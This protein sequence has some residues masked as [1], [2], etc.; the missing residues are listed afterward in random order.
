MA[1]SLKE[2]EKL[3]GKGVKL[4]P[5]PRKT[6][7]APQPQ[8]PKQSFFERFNLLPAG[9]GTLGAV[10]GAVAGPPGIIAGGAAG[11]GLGE[12]IEQLITGKTNIKGIAAETAFG[13]AGGVLGRVLGVGARAA[14]A[15]APEPVKKG[16]Q[17]AARVFTKA[18]TIPTKLA[19]RLKPIDTS[20]ELLKHGLGGKDLGFMKRFAEQ[21]TGREGILPR[22]V[23]DIVAKVGKDIPLPA[24]ITPAK[25]VLGRSAL[26]TP[27]QQKT[28]FQA[29]A[30]T[31]TPGKAPN[32]LNPMDALDSI[33]E[34]EKV[35]FQYINSST[36]LSPN[37]IN[38][39]IGKAYLASSDAIKEVLERS[40]QGADLV[41]LSKTPQLLAQLKQISP[42]LAD[43]FNK[44]KTLADVRAV[45]APFVRLSQMVDITEEAAQSVG[46]GL[47][48]GFGARTLGGVGGFAV[49]GPVGAAAGIASAPF[50]E[51]VEG[52]IRAPLTTGA[53]RLF[54]ILGRARGGIGGL[55][56]GAGA[57]PVSQGVRA[58]LGQVI[59]RAAAL[60]ISPEGVPQRPEEAPTTIEELLS[61]QGVADGGLQG[62]EGVLGEQQP[63]QQ[64]T[65]D[66]VVRAH[67]ELDPEFAD[68]IQAAFEAQSLGEA[69]GKLTAAQEQN[70]SKLDRAD[71]LLSTYESKLDEI[72]T[73]EGFPARLRG[74]FNKLLG[75]IGQA[76]KVQTFTDLRNGTVA[77]LAKALGEVGN[78]SK[79]DIEVAK[80][81]IPRLTDTTEEVR[82]KLETIRS[83]ISKSRQNLL[84][85]TGKVLPQTGGIN[86]QLL[87]Q[88][89]QGGG[90][91]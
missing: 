2:L 57:G 52:A 69:G 12:F 3:L 63:T 78:L 90:F 75:S 82:L 80:A 40:I 5:E 58:G 11:A 27:S 73:V 16:L 24:I 29:I 91:Q 66:D 7:I 81:N 68:R 74:V 48:A 71:V 28:I 13:G 61:G 38:E 51:G 34:L 23:R 72:G 77:M 76:P 83:I 39:Q 62:L 87:Q 19:G 15:V 55:A 10:G 6:R 85:R 20:E 14:K 45:Q 46:A 65:V 60:G 21:V 4:A 49:G 54:S 56:G 41:A 25:T 43:Q 26:I 86:E 42:R 50:I 18:F 88:I 33:K 36:K 30:K 64:V 31:I 32:T 84:E 8:Q 9:L 53:G 79:T 67:L 70:L 44:A 22:V 47:G 1:I 17:I 59:P 89:L 37:I 35:G